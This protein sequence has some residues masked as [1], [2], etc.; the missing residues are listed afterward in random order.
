MIDIEQYDGSL[1]ISYFNEAG[2]IAID[3]IDIPS[4]QMF[5]WEYVQP[6]E[7]S[8][9]GVLSWDNKP[10]KK[11]RARYLSKWRIEEFLLGLDSSITDKFTAHNPK[12][13]FLDIETYVGDEWP[14]PETA[15]TPVTA[16]TFCN[17]NKIVTLGVNPLTANQILSIKNR[18]QEHF[19]DYFTEEIEYNYLKFGTEYDML[20][21]FFYKAIQK[22]PLITGWNVIGYDWVYLIN[23]CKRL[24]IDPSPCSPS[25]KLVGDQQ[26]PMHRL[27]VDYLDIYKKWDRVIDVKENNTLDFVAKA[28]LGIQ[29][30]KYSGT[31]QELYENDFESYIFYN[32]VDT[33]LV[34]LIDEKLNTL[35]TFFIA[36]DM[37]N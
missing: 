35:S 17:G 9:P 20:V 15:K 16:I 6:G 36:L 33:K 21:S 25:H 30:V 27:V 29:K 23:R 32:A 4:D 37:L 22:M 18:I 7:K 12:K 1:K 26:L 31:L 24:N 13:W 5:E 34:E 11:K 10:V 14:K 2:E 8:H 19:K 28:A 3:K